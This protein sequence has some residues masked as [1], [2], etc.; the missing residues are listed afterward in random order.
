MKVGGIEIKNNEKHNTVKPKQISVIS[1][2][3]TQTN[4]IRMMYICKRMDIRLD[5]LISIHVELNG[6]NSKLIKC[7]KR[8]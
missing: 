4:L 1:H 7:R 3:R 2:I 5:L 6:A 8:F